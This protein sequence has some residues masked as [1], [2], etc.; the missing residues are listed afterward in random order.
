MRQDLVTQPIRIK[1]DVYLCWNGEVYETQNDPNVWNHETSDTRLVANELEI[2]FAQEEEDNATIRRKI[3][4]VMATF[5]NAEFSFLILTKTSVSMLVGSFA[6]TWYCSKLIGPLVV[7][8]L[9]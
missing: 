4:E 3:S 5:H 2:I 1:E 7:S 6:G 9:L 8:S